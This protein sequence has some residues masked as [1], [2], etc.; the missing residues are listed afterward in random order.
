[1]FRK[2][3]P[4]MTAVQRRTENII[5]VKITNKTN[6]V[7]ARALSEPFWRQQK[8]KQNK[9]EDCADSVDNC[10]FHIKRKRFNLYEC[11]SFPECDFTEPFGVT[12]ARTKCPGN[13]CQM[14]VDSCFQPYLCRICLLYIV[15]HSMILGENNIP[16][17]K[18]LDT[19]KD[20]LEYLILI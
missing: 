9:S 13:C 1:M 11:D 14:N 12:L 17:T 10:H 3:I 18:S 6:H 20:F 2:L 5:I 16:D 19:A 8:P 7:R 15:Q 4:L